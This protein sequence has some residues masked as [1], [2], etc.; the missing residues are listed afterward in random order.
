MSTDQ[1]TSTN[2]Q[3]YDGAL[4]AALANSRPCLADVE[5]LTE[6]LDLMATFDSNEQR[7]RYLLSSSWMRDRGAVVAARIRDAE[8]LIAKASR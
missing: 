6:L 4:C 8:L 3:A 5:A 2:S 1:S 7:A